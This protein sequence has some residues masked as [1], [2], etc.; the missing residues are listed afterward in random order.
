MSSVSLS[1]PPANPGWK[2]TLLADTEAVNQKIQSSESYAVVNYETSP[3]T[4]ENYGQ[5]VLMSIIK[6]TTNNGSQY[7]WGYNSQLN[8]KTALTTGNILQ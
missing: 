1:N 2:T 3:L 5:E 6:T 4:V 8:F 7:W